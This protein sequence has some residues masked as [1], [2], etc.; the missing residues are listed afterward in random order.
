[1]RERSESYALACSRSSGNPA[2]SG[3]EVAVVAAQRGGVD[4]TLLG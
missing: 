3:G 2:R 1:M 4:R